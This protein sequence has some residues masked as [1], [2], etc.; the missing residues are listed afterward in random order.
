MY[1]IITYNKT[2]VSEIKIKT[3]LNYNY[4]EKVDVDVVVVVVVGGEFKTQSSDSKSMTDT[5]W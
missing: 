4:G 3:N 5:A 2:F 1:C